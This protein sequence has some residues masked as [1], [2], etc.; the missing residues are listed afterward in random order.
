MS[1]S[2]KG[3]SRSRILIVEDDELMGV[4]YERIFKKHKDEFAWHLK[5]NAKE[6][7][8]YLRER[9]VDAAILDWDLPGISGIDFLKA[10]RS[11]PATKALPV[12][13]VSGRARTEDHV[14]ALERGADDFLA[15]PFHVEIL[16]ARLRRLLRR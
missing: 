8:G 16:L 12:I 4:L 3:A 14:L 13:L 15:K 5:P 9:R 7:M 11:N 2:E 1:A 6:A 10:L